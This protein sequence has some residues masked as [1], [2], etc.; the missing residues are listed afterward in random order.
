[1]DNYCKICPRKCPSRKDKS[2]CGCFGKLKIARAALHF[3]EEPCI[4]GHRGSGTVFFSGCNLK[5]VFCQNH[6]IS[7]ENYGKEISVERLAEIFLELQQQGAEN[8]NLV[9]PTHYIDEIISALDIVKDKLNI[10][11]VYN[12]SGYELVSSLEKLKGYI[13]IYL[14]DLKYMD[15]DRALKY[16]NAGNYVEYATSAI[17]YMYKQVGN[18]QLD[19]RGMLKKGVIIRHLILPKG[20][21][22]SI[23]VL[24]WIA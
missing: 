20:H 10:P 9:N 24:E 21:N 22:D 2:Y 19:D 6:Q 18:I 14:P 17:K 4:S 11:V 3:W 8:I 12:S 1:M 5:C 7:L 15:N 23:K 16:S 13:D